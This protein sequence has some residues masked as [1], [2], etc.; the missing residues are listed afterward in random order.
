MKLTLRHIAKIALPLA[1]SATLAYSQNLNLDFTESSDALVVFG[2]DDEVQANQ[3]SAFKTGTPL[4]DV[5]QSVTVVTQEQI[6]E[7]AVDSIA[8]IVDYTPGVNNSQGEGHRDSVVFRGVRSTAD[9]FQDGVRDDVQYYR[10][11]YNVEQVEIL[12]G[13]NALS[14][15]RGGSGGVINRVQKKAEVG[16]TF[17][18]YLGRV[19]SFGAT[20][21]QIDYNYS[22]SDDAAL[23]L[24]A[25]YEYLNNHR[26]FY[27]GNRYDIN[28]TFTY[29]L[30]DDTTF[31]FSYEYNNHERF[32]DRGIP[33]GDNGKPVE[34]LDGVVFG[35]EDL[36]FSEFEAHVVRGTLEH[37]FS[38]TWKASVTASYGNFDKL[39]QNFYASDYVESTNQVELDGYRDTTQRERFQL[40][41]DFIGEFSTGSVDHK[42]LLGTELIHTSND[43]VRLNNEWASN[44][45][46]QQFFNA[47]NFNLRNGVFTDNAGNVLDTATFSDFAD[48]TQVTV[49]TFSFFLQDEVSIN[50]YIDLTLGA[51]VDNFDI[52]LD[53]FDSNGNSTRSSQ[54]DAFVTPRAGLVIKPQ[55]NLSLYASYSESYVPASGGQYAN[56]GDQLDPDRFT[57]LEAG[58]KYDIQDNL[59]F[60]ASVFQIDQTLTTENNAGQQVEDDAQTNGFEF[61]LKG[62][63]TDRWFVNAGYSYL[64]GETSTGATPRE[65]PQNSFSIWNRYQVT[66]Q[67]GLGFGVI[68]QDETLTDNGSSSKLPSYVRVDAAAY[69]TLSDNFRVQLNIENLFDTD[70]YPTSHSSHQATIGAPINAGIT[71]VGR[72]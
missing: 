34:A 42:V 35:D 38:D 64:D 7:Q 30:S 51:R 56:L 21:A 37:N 41:G 58:F 48:N 63:I 25:N 19:N 28:P 16:D 17:G 1:F 8:D 29:N 47:S 14:F 26:D 22:L 15:G 59:S 55:E 32:I 43:N 52:E 54:T 3:I 4:V 2:N 36:N 23:R 6:Q 13:P 27:D 18:E 49:N 57:N 5:P 65:L 33:T 66:D 11:L 60:T 10:G 39:Y 62:N 71:F 45:D 20:T 12:R 69:Y 9:F 68:Y 31:R 72:F 67:F 40:A 70:Y 46:D 61:Q 44:G 50:E 53:S 24:N